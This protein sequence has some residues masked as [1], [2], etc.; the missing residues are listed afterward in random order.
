MNIKK[1]LSAVLVLA[2]AEVVCLAN[3][4]YFMSIVLMIAAVLTA[5]SQITSGGKEDIKSILR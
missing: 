3:S 4:W 2:V 5:A 1:V